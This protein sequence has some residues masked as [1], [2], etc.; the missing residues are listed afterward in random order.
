MIWSVRDGDRPFPA[1]L[2]ISELKLHAACR[3]YDLAVTHDD[4]DEVDSPHRRQAAYFRGE[5]LREL[6]DLDRQIDKL[7]ATIRRQSG[8]QALHQHL[9][10]SQVDL[11]TALTQRDHLLNMLAALGGPRRRAAHRPAEQLARLAEAPRT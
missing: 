8:V 7:K 5:L 11:R 2:I 3:V 10:Q 4:N 9:A 1:A 6:G